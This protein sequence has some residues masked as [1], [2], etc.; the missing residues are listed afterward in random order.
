MASLENNKLNNKLMMNHTRRRV[1][2]PE[3]TLQQRQQ[4]LT[5]TVTQTLKNQDSEMGDTLASKQLDDE[6]KAKLYNQ[7]LQRYLIYYDHRNGQPLHVQS[8]G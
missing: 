6:E 7:M 2:V 1:L 3:N 5:S 4:I 8:R